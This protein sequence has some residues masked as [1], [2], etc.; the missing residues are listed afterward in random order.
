MGCA[1]A[2]ENGAAL[3]ADGAASRI[4]EHAACDEADSENE[5]GPQRGSQ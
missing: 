5:G 2:Q 4:G 3:M 1:G